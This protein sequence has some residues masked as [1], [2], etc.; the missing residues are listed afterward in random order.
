M[1][2]PI[3]RSFAPISAFII[4]PV[5]QF[6]LIPYAESERGQAS[7]S[8]LLGTGEGRG[9]ALVFVLVSIVGMIVTGA[10]FFTKTYRS[11]TAS[12]DAGD[13]NADVTTG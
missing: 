2:L 10:A 5:A 3:S 12:Y 13:V 6:W 9:I 8:W 1:L 4:G 7:L 11:L